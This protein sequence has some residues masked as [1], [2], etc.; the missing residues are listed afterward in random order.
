MAKKVEDRWRSPYN[1]ALRGSNTAERSGG[2]GG[3]ASAAPHLLGLRVRIP[4][5]V[6]MWFTVNAKAQARIIRTKKQVREKY[7]ERTRK[8]IQGEKNPAEARFSA[9]ARTDPGAHLVLCTVGTMPLT[10]G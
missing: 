8:R 2:G 9:P 7:K 5:G 6:W 3:S 10:R 4:P 1:D